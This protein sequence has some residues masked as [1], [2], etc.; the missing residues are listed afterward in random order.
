M[1][2]GATTMMPTL[3]DV[4]SVPHELPACTVCCARARRMPGEVRRMYT[5]REYPNLLCCRGA[6]AP[7]LSVLL[8]HLAPHGQERDNA[9]PCR[10]LS[11]MC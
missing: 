6:F 3:P 11:G 2:D 1:N 8:H 4:S 9:R 7:E 5:D 10:A